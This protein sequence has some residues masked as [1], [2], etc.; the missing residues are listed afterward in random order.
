MKIS[1]E[2]SGELDARQTRRSDCAQE[3]TKRRRAHE[4]FETVFNAR[5]VAIHVLADEMNFLV[6]KRLQSLC[7]GDDLTGRSA[8][9]ATTRVRH[10]A[11]RTKFV[12]AFDDRNESDVWRVALERRNVPR[13][14]FATLTEIENPSFSFA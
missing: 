8:A 11:E 12:A 13:V 2:R 3:T 6:A 4:S 7:F 14:V 9:F 10:D 1:R 5:P